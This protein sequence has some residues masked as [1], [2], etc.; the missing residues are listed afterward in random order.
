MRTT[1]DELLQ[2]ANILD[3]ISQH[4]KLRKAGKDYAGLCPFHKEKTPSFTVSVEKQMFYCFSCREGGNAVNFLMKYENLSFQEA[5]ETLARQYGMEI[6]RKDSGKRT[7]QYYQRNLQNS[8]TALQYLH[9]RGMTDDV[10]EEFK[11]GYSDRTS[12]NLKGFLKNSGIPNDI[13]L[14]TGIVRIKDGALYEMFRGRIIIP[15]IDVNKKIIGFGGRTIEKEGFPKYVNSPES[16][17]FSKRSSL[18]G[19][20]KTRKFISESNEVF[21]VEGYFDFISLYMNGFKNIVSTLGTAVTEGQISKLRN[22][23]ENITLMLDGD[24]AGVKSALRLIEL[25]AE[26]DIHGSMIVLPEAHDPDSFVRKEG[27]EAVQEAIT[28]KKPILDYYFDYYI[29]KHSIKTPEG[30]GSLIK[31]VLP[32]VEAIRNSV[33]RRLY[34]KRISELTGVEENHFVDSHN[35]RMAGFSQNN[36]ESGGIIERKVIN[37]CMTNPRLLEP[38]KGKEV[39]SYIKSHHVREIL[40]RLLIHVEEKQNFEVH[41]FVQTLENDDLRSLVLDAVFDS[42]EFVE[43]EP[44]KV[45][46]DYFKHIEKQFFKE[47]SK[48]ITEKLSEAEGRGDEKEIIM[49]LEKKRQVLTYMKNKFL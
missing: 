32:H 30:K 13:F 21:I 40:S 24:E 34:I 35:E 14:S 20:D 49:L 46:F 7:G 22:Y 18:F 1:L 48:K 3:V 15:I 41:S 37:A 28:K 39:L 8:K 17:V 45:F 6:L 47:E 23:T 33:T 4:V 26:M 36:S 19:I 12:G 2:R 16:T 5:Q 43:D 10:I 9:N 31:A 11:L 29:T 27:V 42:T 25:F 38:Y 44:E